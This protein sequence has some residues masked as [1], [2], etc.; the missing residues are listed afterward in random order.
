MLLLELEEC[1][2]KV[3]EDPPTQTIS[4]STVSGAMFSLRSA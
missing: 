1:Q 2:I 4:G 3:S